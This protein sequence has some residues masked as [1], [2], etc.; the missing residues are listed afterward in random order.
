M[1]IFFCILALADLVFNFALVSRCISDLRASKSDDFCRI[2]SFVSH[3]AELLSACFTAHFTIQRFIAVR[4]PLSV[5]VEKNI[6][7]LHYVI[8]SLFIVSGISYCFVLTKKGFYE[9]CEEEL[10]LNW[11]ISDALLSFVIPFTI[12]AILNLLIIFHLRKT[13]RNHQGLSFSKRPKKDILPLHP[14]KRNSI[15]F[16]SVSTSRAS[17]NTI[18]RN[19]KVLQKKNFFLVLQQEGRTNLVLS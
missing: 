18:V 13:S 9:N 8:V 17:E 1:I 7:L 3:L 15:S 11:F 10:D 2:L 14:R 6:H 16:D 4:F 19:M 5:F 12:I